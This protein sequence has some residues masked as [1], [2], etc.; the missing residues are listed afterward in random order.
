M[1]ALRLDV[2]E[3]VELSYEIP[4]LTGKGEAIDS[5]TVCINE[6]RQGI[7]ISY[8]LVECTEEHVDSLFPPEDVNTLA[9]MTKRILRDLEMKPART[10]LQLREHSPGHN[11]HSLEAR[12]PVN[13]QRDS[14]L[15]IITKP[16]FI[17]KF[18][19]ELVL[20]H[21]AMHAK[22]RWEYRF[23]SAHPL[24]NAGEWLDVLWHFSIDGRLEIW[25]RPHYSRT[26]RLEEAIRVFR[27]LCP[28]K[29]LQ[30]RVCQLCD[31]LWGKEITFAK[32]LEIGKE[33]GLEPAS[34][35][36]ELVQRSQTGM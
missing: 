32:L 36:Q 16:P 13:K 17:Y 7:N 27:G 20:W 8:A 24:V 9:R 28:G 22:D 2:V 30:A 34:G 6:R 15:I 5:T 12:A 29:D 18:G 33:L 25:R 11:L 4:Y 21:Q 14:V 19:H 35:L 23:P 1:M 31:Q 10:I 26:E 3:E